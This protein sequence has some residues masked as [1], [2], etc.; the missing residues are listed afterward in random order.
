MIFVYSGTG[1]SYQI[2][3]RIAD[4]L[5][6]SLVNIA[7]ALRFERFTYNAKGSVV[8][9]VFPTC[10][11]GVNESV[12]AFAENLE[13]RNPGRTFVL[14]TCGEDSTGGA[15]QFIEVL[16]GRLRIDAVY[17]VLMPD[18]RIIDREP[19]T[20]EEADAIIARG[21]EEADSALGSFA[22]G[23]SGDWRRHASGR[24]WRSVHSS[25]DGSRGTEGFRHSSRCIQ[26]RFCAQFCPTRTIV[27]YDRYPIWDEPE[28]DHCM[29]CMEICPRQAIE[30]GGSTEGRRRW[31]N[32]VFY[33]MSIGIL[34]KY[35]LSRYRTCP[36]GPTAYIIRSMGV[37]CSRTPADLHHSSRA[38]W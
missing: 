13:I 29:A 19:P 35:D 30:Y 20:R 1:N 3:R 11:A 25:Y 34:P 15:E 38:R 31:Y 24:D 32:P 36:P 17:D 23:A 26:C 5:G 12:R 9:F 10:E 21:L 37:P 18:N 22:E 28:C 14:T 27:F 2:A 6:Q 33:E 4:A 16:D 8:G 7:S